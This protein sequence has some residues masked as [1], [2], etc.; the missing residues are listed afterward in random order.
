[1]PAWR[2]SGSGG[3][4]GSSGVLRMPDLPGPNTDYLR[5]NTSG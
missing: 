2:D 5:G 1:M 4:E 3:L